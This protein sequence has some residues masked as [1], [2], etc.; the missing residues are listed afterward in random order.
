MIHMIHLTPTEIILAI[1]CAAIVLW[2][3]IY[4]PKLINRRSKFHVE[5]TQ[6]ERERAYINACWEEIEGKRRKEAN[7]PKKKG[8]KRKKIVKMKKQP[9]EY[10]I[11]VLTILVLLNMLIYGLLN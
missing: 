2:L 8:K 5:G 4:A 1:T 6:E 7:A 3:Y 10:V 11:P 9:G